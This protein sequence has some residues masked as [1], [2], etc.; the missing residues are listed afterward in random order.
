MIQKDLG[1]SII[2]KAVNW[3]EGNVLHPS[4]LYYEFQR[5]D[6]I[7]KQRFLIENPNFYG[8]HKIKIEEDDLQYNIFKIK[9][10]ECIFSD[11]TL[12]CKNFEN[13]YELKIDL[14]Q[15][16]NNPIEET[17]IFL[18]IPECSPKNFVFGEQDSRYKSSK[19]QSLNDWEN[20]EKQFITL[21]ENVFL[22]M[23]THP[24]VNCAFLPLGKIKIDDGVI[25]FLEYIP[26]SLSIKSSDKLYQ[27]SLSLIEFMRNK[28]DI[29]NQDIDFIK[30][31]ENFLSYI[32]KTQLNINLK[33]AISNI[34]S[35]MQ[36]KSTTPEILYKECCVALSLISSINQIFENVENTIYDHTNIKYVFDNIISKI[37]NSLEQEIS[38]KYRTYRFNKKDNIFFINLN[39]KLPEFI[40]VSIKKQANTKDEEILEWIKTALICEK[41]DMEFNLEKRAIGFERKQEFL[42]PDIIVKKD[43][44]TFNIQT[45]VIENKIDNVIIVTQS[46]SLLN[47]FEPEE[48]YL[49]QEK[50]S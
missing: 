16:K 33:H 10:I 6:I 28:L 2:P 45:K 19:T 22:D 31:T 23:D 44:I 13:E 42:N 12:F 34:E 32:E 7:N 20:E 25:H 3:K 5:I 48:I 18:S 30:N 47:K 14:N 24:P 1:F 26:P 38:E 39:Y 46:N 17:Y 9:E 41:T 50:V 4:V 21:D 8:I 37:Q 40:K 27:T 43:F 11:G 49:Y 15:Y 29:L 36:L 35:I